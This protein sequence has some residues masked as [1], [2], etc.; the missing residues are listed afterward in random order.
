MEPPFLTAPERLWWLILLPVLYWLALPPRPRRETLT[1]HLPQWLAAAA[2]L[3]RRPP[4]FRRW[5]FLLLVLAVVGAVLAATGPSL[6][7]TVG[8]SRLCV[9][10]DSSASMAHRVGDRTA[11]DAAIAALRTGLMNVPPHVEIVVVIAGG[12]VA[13][14]HGAAARAFADP[15]QPAGAAVDL[16]AVVAAAGSEPDTAVWTITDGQSPPLPEASALTLCGAS[17][18]NAAI[19]AVEVVDAWPLPELRLRVQ[20]QSRSRAPWRGQLQAQGA[21]DAAG[22]F[23]VVLQPEER[24]VAELPLRRTAAG[25]ALTLE[26]QM[27]GDVLPLDDRVVLALPPLPLPTIA[28]LGDRTS[29]IVRTAV[30][31]LADEVGGKVIEGDEL[32]RAGFLFVEGGVAELPPG[33]TRAIAFGC[34]SP[35]AP[36]PEVW[37]SP[38]IVDWDRQ[39]PWTAGL[40]LSELEVA[41]ALHGILPAGEPL[42]LGGGPGGER[43]PLLVAVPGERRALHF[44]FRLQD[45]N[46]ALLPAFPQLLRRAFLGSFGAA[47]RIPAPQL[48]VPGTESDLRALPA[49]G[50]P[51]PAFGSPARDLGAYCLLAALLAL[52]IRAYVR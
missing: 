25:G 38:T 35:A 21:I 19:A 4:R 48:P 3:R 45:S 32:S 49:V 43:V 9:V 47:H 6:P 28:V 24:Q 18:D 10:V 37:P 30:A 5:R 14:R 44:A 11:A 52:A 40:D 17:G 13:R 50:R 2:R 33:A 31:V 16:A 8:P 15:L 1:A 23:A 7:G 42:L 27:P 34:R 41:H 36:L 39:S 26:L 51:L 29:P 20:L 46:L 12:G 22:P